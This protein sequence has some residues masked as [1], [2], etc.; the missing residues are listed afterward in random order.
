M[1]NPVSTYRIQFHKDFTFSDLENIIPYLFQLGIK[2]LYASPIFEAVPGSMHGYDVV[3][4]LNIN[5]EIGTLQ[6]LRSINK[7]LKKLGIGWLQDIVPNHMAFH[8]NNK[9]L[10]D[11]LENGRESEYANVFDIFW[12]SPVHNGKLMVPFL[13]KPLDEVIANKE[14]KVAWNEKPVLDYF[15]QQYPLNKL[16][17]ENN[18][19]GK[20][21]WLK[22]VNEDTQL[23]KQVVESQYYELCF[24]QETNTQI[25]FRRFFTVNSLICLNIQNKEVF[26]RYHQLIKT[27]VDEGI[28]Q[29]LRVDHIDGLYDPKTYLVRLR[30]LAGPETYIVVEKILEEG[31][32][33]PADWPVQGNTGY[34]FLSTINNLFTSHES[35]KIF[36]AFYRSMETEHIPVQ[37]QVFQKKRLILD[38][39]MQGELENLYS[40]FTTL[41]LADE[42]ETKNISAGIFKKAIAEILVRCPVYRFYGNSMPLNEAESALFNNLLIE[43]GKNIPELISVTDVLGNCLL[44]KPRFSNEDYRQRALKFYQ[45][46]MQF[47]GPL[48]AKG[49]EDTLMYTYNRFIDHNEVG[50]SPGSFG[51]DTDKFHQLM[52]QRQKLW[53]LSMNAS[54]THDT[55]RGED[56]RARLNVLSD[57]AE[58]WIA[59]VKQWQQVNADQKTNNAPDAN[60]EYFIYQT[61]MGAYPM[62]GQDE[63]DFENR[64]KEYLTKALREAKQ[65]T[66]W[67]QSNEEYEQAAINFAVS[68]LNKQGQFWKSFEGFH[69]CI[70]DLGIINSLTQVLL[71][72][73]C[74][75]MPDIYQGCELWELSLV[76]PDNRRP[77]DYLLR[78]SFIDKHANWEDL[79]S[80]RHNGHIKQNLTAVMLKARSENAD[81]FNEGEYIP[82]RIKGKYKDNVFAFARHFNGK[83]YISAVPLHFAAISSS[84]DEPTKLD[85]DDTR[86]VLPE[87]APFSWKNLLTGKAGYSAKNIDVKELFSDIPLAFLRLQQSQNKRSAGVLMH[88]TSLPSLFGVGD[89]GPQAYRFADFLSASRQRVWQMLPVNPIDA[90]SAYSPYAATSAMAGNV[91]LISPELLVNERLLDRSELDKFKPAGDRVNYAEAV[92]LKAGLFNKAYQK[93]VDTK[94]RA[95]F[96]DFKRTEAWWLDDFAAYQ[97]LKDKFKDD[98]WNKWPDEFKFRKAGALKKIAEEP[99]LDQIK[100]LQFVFTKQ[101]ASFKKYCNAKD[102]TLLGDMSFYISYD[103]VDVWSKPQ[104]FKLDNKGNITGVAGVPPDYF[105]KTGQ[106][107]GMPVYDWDKIKVDNYDWWEKRIKRNLQ[108][109][110]LIRMDHFRA[111]SAYWEVPG[112]SKDATHGKW[113]P[114]PGADLFNHINHA[115]GELPFVAE[116]LGDIDE[117]VYRLRDQF[118]LP[119][120]RV[121]QFAFD[122]AM[123]I[124]EHIPHNYNR[125]SIAYTGTHDNNTIKGWFENDIDRKTQKRIQEYAAHKVSAKNINKVMVRMCYASAAKTVIIPMQDILGLDSSARMNIPSSSAGNWTWRLNAGSLT[126]KTVKYLQNLCIEYNR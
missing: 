97:F 112:G 17:Y 56:V 35:K 60:D 101:W 27:L 57:L 87:S 20:D 83:W 26:D 81:V 119:G 88:I 18:S 32:Q 10:M 58:E 51:L 33:F 107:W 98:P 118:N 21:T 62:P 55:K 109:F 38:N 25:N 1:Y 48:M 63:D 16:S 14:L 94:D 64:L 67:A 91:L 31:E 15:G 23:L 47:T 86:I 7:K 79:W 36:S 34:D 54:A 96:E 43:V 37:E 69:Q 123:P 104:L 2:T 90:G 41:K 44:H 42:N 40:L 74:P 117:A 92:K 39:N 5:P 84:G 82:L 126:P 80:N 110:D 76:D 4:P 66:N 113:Q 125:N 53:P 49:V 22:K 106:L 19:A 8:P 12:D 100:W 124:S 85:W 75:G 111:F 73:T 122:S 50:D 78:Q 71:K 93:F 11:V 114:G 120:M 30:E 9:W 13:G 102:I 3:D 70:A 46:L 103:S 61:L 6:Q 115:I 121:L 108:F 24:W 65:H 45:R 77:V 105:S 99:A 28:F 89:I 72:L 116:D 29:G 95:E 68:L 52:L 59:Q